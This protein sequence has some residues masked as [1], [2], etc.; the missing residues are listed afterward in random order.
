MPLHGRYPYDASKVCADVLA[1]CYAVTYDLPVV[2]SRCA[3]IYGG[4]DL[5]WSR[6]IPGTVRSV[7][8]G[9]EPILPSDGTPARD[10]LYIADA[11][12]AYLALGEHAG[13]AEARGRAFNFGWAE[14]VRALDLVE[15]ILQAAGSPLRP[16]ILGEAKGEIDNSFSIR[17]S[18]EATLAGSRRLR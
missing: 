15:R 14:P 13:E 6:L 2:V 17:L 4:A 9:E 3:N 7:L 16:K 11:V 8:L 12:R 18:R 1:R 10:Y 5:N